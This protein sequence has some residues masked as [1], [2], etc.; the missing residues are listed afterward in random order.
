MLSES[1]AKLHK[2][3]LKHM[4]QNLHMYFVC[5]LSSH[6]IL[7][8][9]LKLI[10]IL[11]K[12]FTMGIAL[13][14]MISTNA[15]HICQHVVLCCYIYN[16]ACTHTHTPTRTHWRTTRHIKSIVCLNMSNRLKSNLKLNRSSFSVCLHF[17]FN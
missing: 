17:K 16:C 13:L 6:Q 3:T 5:Y 11:S 4:Y 12:S 8:L 15:K 9:H 7:Y 10:N 14:A 2:E 1:Y